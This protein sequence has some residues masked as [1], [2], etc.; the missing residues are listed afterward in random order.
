[1]PPDTLPATTDF[2]AWARRSG[3]RAEFVNGTAQHL[4]AGSLAHDTICGNLFAA[5]HAG[6][7]GIERHVFLGALVEVPGVG[8]LSP[9]LVFG[10]WS[11][12][13]DEVHVRGPQLV[14]EVT[15]PDTA[16]RDRGFK[17]KAVQTV[18]ALERYVLVDEAEWSVEVFARG[19][20]DAWRY[21][22]LTGTED[23]LSIPS[24]GFA[25][26]LAAVYRGVFR[27]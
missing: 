11:P 25:M 8:Y 17:W 20:D 3:G 12:S 10:T 5:L 24:I 13:G 16:A 6:A 9:D 19:A 22:R 23:V 7:D 4:P 14:V 21:E 2:L 1:M 27:A 26:P 15:A 18:A